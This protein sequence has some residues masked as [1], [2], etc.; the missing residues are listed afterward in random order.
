MLTSDQLS[1]H[2]VGCGAEGLWFNAGCGTDDLW[3]GAGCSADELW[4]GAGCGD[5]LRFGEGFGADS[6]FWVSVIEDESFNANLN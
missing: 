4:F 2:G 6:W 3:F 1:A 5:D